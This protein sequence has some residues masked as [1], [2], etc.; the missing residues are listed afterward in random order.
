MTLASRKPRRPEWLQKF[1]PRPVQD[2]WCRELPHQR[3]ERDAAMHRGHIE[4]WAGVC[5][6]DY[7]IFIPRHHPP[8]QSDALEGRPFIPGRNRAAF[9]LIFEEFETAVCFE[10]SA[11][12]R[13]VRRSSLPGES[14]YISM[15][16]WKEAE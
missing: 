12:L 9:L 14:C 13:G 11:S 7:G 3:G 15:A 5:K 1:D 16:A 6:T 2:F 10:V 4:I 8:A